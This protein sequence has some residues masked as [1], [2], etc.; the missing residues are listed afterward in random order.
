MVETA[1]I[2]LHIELAPII[3]VSLLAESIRTGWVKPNGVG[4][5]LIVSLM[6]CSVLNRKILVDSD[7]FWPG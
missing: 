7:L 1:R 3:K 4:L 2:Y 5:V 6:L